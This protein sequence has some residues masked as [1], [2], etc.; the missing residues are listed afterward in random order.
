MHTAAG[1]ADLSNAALWTPRMPEAIQYPTSGDLI[2]VTTGNFT[3]TVPA[4]VNKAVVS[5]AGMNEA[6]GN[7]DVPVGSALEINYETAVNEVR[8]DFSVLKPGK[9]ALTVN[10]VITMVY[11]DPAFSSGH[12]LGVVEL[13]MNLGGADDYSM[14]NATEM[15][16]QVKYSLFFANRRVVWKYIRKDDKALT[17]RDAGDNS[18]FFKITG[19]EFVSPAPI[20][21]SE[22]PVTSL[23]LLFSGYPRL[24]PLP[25][26]P[27]HALGRCMLDDGH[28]YFCAEMYLNY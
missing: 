3:V 21:L 14:V 20:P 18:Y 7:Y 23:E 9:Y 15:I 5:F 11:Y 28:A 1:V 17:I 25:N 2:Q 19:N 8:V 16:R 24:H 26:P 10:A 13:F 12:M 27:M 4:P 6:T 22:R